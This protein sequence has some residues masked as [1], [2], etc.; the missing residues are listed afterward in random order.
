MSEFW[1]LLSEFFHWKLLVPM[2]CT[3]I[4]CFGFT[5]T[6]MAIGIDD[7]SFD[8]YFDQGYLLVQG[9]VTPVLINK[10]FGI[11]QLRP[12]ITDFIAIMVFFIATVFWGVLLKK[13]SNNKLHW[14]SYVIFACL[15]I[16]YPLMAEIFIY[17]TASISICLGFALTALALYLSSVFLES[18]KVTHALIVIVLLY[19]TLSL[20]ESFASVY[21]AGVFIIL[22]CECLFS[23]KKVSMQKYG[24]TVLFMIVFLFA[25]TRLKMGITTFL[26]NRIFVSNGAD[27]SVA[28]G[29][30]TFEAI[31]HSL[32]TSVVD[33]YGL[34]GF[35][36]TGIAFL[37]LAL[38][39]L[40][41]F[42]FTYVIKRKTPML[43]LLSLGLTVSIFSLS[44]FRG[45]ATQYR[46]CQ[47]F[48]I[49]IAF[50]FCLLTHHLLQRKSNALIKGSVVLVAVIMICAQTYALNTWFY[51][52]HMRYVEDTRTVEEIGYQLT[53]DYKLSKPI[54]FV[55]ETEVSQ[56]IQDY[57]MI[58]NDSFAGK[59]YIYMADL[60]HIK[61]TDNVSE[62]IGL[63]F[64][65]WSIVT[66]GVTDGVANP[67]LIKFFRMNGYELHQG[68]QE[69]FNEATVLSEP[70]PRWPRKGSI[71]ET[72]RYIVVHF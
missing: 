57:T 25:G 42:T 14:A 18:K 22:I 45:H 66:F 34:K 65:Q 32:L 1:L 9:R 41:I 50:V 70:K 4:A 67:E 5:L 2:I 6:H 29:T 17:M 71:Y 51:V 53:S 60:F 39:I 30:D 21:L 19:F 68:T 28:W 63:P 11:Y 44:I 54:V 16:S 8:R 62:T 37:V 27:F 31:T 35:V 26:R 36:N 10:I 49:F 38:F 48:A 24:T 69:M 12:F 13:V 33:A 40:W 52:E 15:L 72:E 46:T 23:N 61:P 3:L 47:V 56:N 59:C 58:D 7:T 64:L 20:Y 43:F 55:G